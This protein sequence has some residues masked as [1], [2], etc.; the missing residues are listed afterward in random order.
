ML[1][2][3]S[4]SIEVSADL[5]ERSLPVHKHKTCYSR[6]SIPCIPTSWAC[7]PTLTDTICSSQLLPDDICQPFHHLFRRP[8]VSF[9][10]LFGPSCKCNPRLQGVQG[11]AS[12]VDLRCAR[13][14]EDGGRYDS[15]SSLG[16]GGAA[17]VMKGIWGFCVGEAYCFSHANS[18]R[19]L[20]EK[21]GNLVCEFSDWKRRKGRSHP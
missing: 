16:F 3:P 14:G 8:L 10:A 17:S 9:D 12:F 13:G 15:A 4:N 7:C 21:G 2:S 20:L 6:S 1:H 11:Q 5:D 19:P 18:L